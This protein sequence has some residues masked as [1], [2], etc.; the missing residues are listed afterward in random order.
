MEPTKFAVKLSLLAGIF[1]SATAMA[2]GSVPIEDNDVFEEKYIDC[3]MSGA[4]NDCFSSIFSGHLVPKVD[5]DQKRIVN[6]INE[7]WTKILQQCHP[8]KVHRAGKT[9]KADIFDGRKYVIECSN[10]SFIGLHI[11]FL[12][13]KG[14]WYVSSVSL[15]DS[16]SIVRDI[17]ETP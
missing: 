15:D 10:D 13:V 5:E 17:L 4:N 8:Y 16:D 6:G 12:R 7:H 11:K 3:I 2:S 1:L 9:I 14:K